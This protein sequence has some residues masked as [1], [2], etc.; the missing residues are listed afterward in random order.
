MH[1]TFVRY[2]S[3]KKF[4]LRKGQFC[5]CLAHLVG[6][7]AARA[8]S[9]RSLLTGGFLQCSWLARRSISGEESF[10]RLLLHWRNQLSYSHWWPK[11]LVGLWNWECSSG[12]VICC[13]FKIALGPESWGTGHSIARRRQPYLLFQFRKY[14]FTFRWREL[15]VFHLHHSTAQREAA[16]TAQGLPLLFQ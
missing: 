10:G 13:F 1:F 16:A 7:L 9:G 12:H 6:A 4:F 11:G 8:G 14:I 5:Q 15:W 2:N 3:V